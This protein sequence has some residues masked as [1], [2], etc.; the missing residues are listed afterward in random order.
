MVTNLA[1]LF[2][3][4]TKLVQIKAIWGDIGV[5][6]GVFVIFLNEIDGTLNLIGY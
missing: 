3:F 4:G 6:G 1:Q 5:L 2:K